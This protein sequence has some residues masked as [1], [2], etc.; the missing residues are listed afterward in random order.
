[1]KN[2]FY[3]DEYIPH[4]KIKKKSKKLK[5]TDKCSCGSGKKYKD[6]CYDNLKS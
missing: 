6:C 5:L 3:E 4:Q 1:M 2:N